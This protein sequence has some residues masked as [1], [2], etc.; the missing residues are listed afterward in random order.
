MY[1]LRFGSWCGVSSTFGQLVYLLH[2]GSLCFFYVL[3][4]GVSS[5]FLQLEYLLYECLLVVVA[6]VSSTVIFVRYVSGGIFYFVL[7]VLDEVFIT[8]IFAYCCS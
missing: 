3:A 4:A 7:Q 2:F 1:L 8:V 6:E 5:T